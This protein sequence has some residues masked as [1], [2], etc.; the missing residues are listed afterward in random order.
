MEH[1]V[2][3]HKDLKAKNTKEEPDNVVPHN[4][5]DSRVEEGFLRAIL[6]GLSWNVIR[7]KKQSS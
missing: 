2:L 5:G 6:P 1:I 3:E 4:R 7:M